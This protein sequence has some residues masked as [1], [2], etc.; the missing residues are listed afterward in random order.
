MKGTNNTGRDGDSIHCWWKVEGGRKTNI[1]TV[2]VSTKMKTKIGTTTWTQ[3]YRSS[4]SYH[5]DAS[6]FITALFIVD[7]KSTSP[8]AH[9][10]MK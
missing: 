2:D 1:F 7:K 3:L 4:T 8:N 10:P 5:R 9:Q 6:V